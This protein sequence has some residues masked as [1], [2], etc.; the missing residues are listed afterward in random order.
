MPARRF[1]WYRRFMAATALP[2]VTSLAL[3]LAPAEA[4]QANQGLQ[5]GW[6]IGESGQVNGVAHCTRATLPATPVDPEQHWVLSLAIR[7]VQVQH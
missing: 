6:A 5:D 7:N 3:M 2:A 4:T 1:T